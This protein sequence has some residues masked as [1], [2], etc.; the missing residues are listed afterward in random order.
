M[1]KWT[2]ILLIITIVSAFI[3]VLAEDQEIVVMNGFERLETDVEPII[4]D[5]GY[6][7]VPV[8]ALA[9]AV[10]Y[11]VTYF[12][13]ERQVTLVKDDVTLLIQLDSDTVLVNG[14]EELLPVPATIYQDR[15][16][17][18]L[19]FV[20]EM[21]QKK[22]NYKD[23][24]SKAVVWVTDFDV[25][26]NEPFDQD[27]YNTEDGHIYTLKG[28]QSTERGIQL[29]DTPEDV[30]ESYGVPVSDKTYEDFRVITYVGDYIIGDIEP[31]TIEFSIEGGKVTNVT[32]IK[33]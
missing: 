29:G 23:Y 16:M 27:R 10:G 21:M 33:P 14:E 25:L 18:P 15:T 5:P 13:E 30:L 19:R 24:G 20:S 4:V 31:Q 8:A 17:V 7:L 1:K 6:T 26:V 32:V 11:E 2:A 12:H 28:N 22:V 9:R 3:P